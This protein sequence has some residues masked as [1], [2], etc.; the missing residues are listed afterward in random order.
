MEELVQLIIGSLRS[1]KRYKSGGIQ[2]STRI[3]NEMTDRYRF[4]SSVLKELF[5]NLKRSLTSFSSPPSL[6]RYLSPNPTVSIPS[7][8]PPAL[9][10]AALRPSSSRW[11]RYTRRNFPLN[12]VSPLN[13]RNLETHPYS[14]SNLSR[15]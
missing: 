8:L 5:R 4:D 10:L 15:R 13:R 2:L 11:H 3:N 7:P 1:D 9:P 12:F 6:F 14:V